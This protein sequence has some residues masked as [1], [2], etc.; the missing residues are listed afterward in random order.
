MNTGKI[1]Y[2]LNCKHKH[3]PQDSSKE[4]M[5]YTCHTGVQ[6]PLGDYK[7]DCSQSKMKLYPDIKRNKD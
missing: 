3:W 1:K 7:S 6:D 4:S 2:V 5:P